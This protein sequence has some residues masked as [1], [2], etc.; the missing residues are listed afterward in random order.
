MLWRGS[1]C[2]AMP[3]PGNAPWNLLLYLLSNVARIQLCCRGRTAASRQ[4]SAWHWQMGLTPSYPC[5][6]EAAHVTERVAGVRDR[7]RPLRV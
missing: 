6:S 4:R 5:V 1:S 7:H 2:G 3:L